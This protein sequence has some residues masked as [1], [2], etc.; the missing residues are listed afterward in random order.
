MVQIA[1]SEF[2]KFARPGLIFVLFKPFSRMTTTK[3][4]SGIQTRIFGVG[5]HA[6]HLT[7]RYIRELHLIPIRSPIL[8][9]ILYLLPVIPLQRKHVT[10]I[11]KE[12]G[13]KEHFSNSTFAA[14]NQSSVF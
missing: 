13:R 2:F 3:Y 4:F 7:T 14:S 11:K 9:S 1:V 12:E 10:S 5:E 8:K 6:D